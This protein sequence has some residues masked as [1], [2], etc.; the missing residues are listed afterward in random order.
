MILRKVRKVV[1]KC[2]ST[3]V[4]ETARNPETQEESAVSIAG[5]NNEARLMLWSFTTIP[6]LR[7]GGEVGGHLSSHTHTHH[8][9]R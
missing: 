3:S 6:F 5:L 8:V 7:A 4:T 1:V 2:V 9:H